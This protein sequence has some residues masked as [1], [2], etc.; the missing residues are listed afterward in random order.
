M[1]YFLSAI[2]LITLS[3]C[4]THYIYMENSIYHDPTPLKGNFGGQYSIGYGEQAEIPIASPSALASLKINTCPN[5]GNNSQNGC[6][7]GAITPLRVD[8]RLKIYEGLQ[9]YR[10]PDTFGI[11]YQI[12]GSDDFNHLLSV[13][14]GWGGLSQKSQSQNLFSTSTTENA[15][16]KVS[17]RELSL[18]YGYRIS[19]NHTVIAQ[20]NYV[21]INTSYTI[22]T[23]VNGVVTSNAHYNDK[24]SHSR[25]GPAYKFTSNWFY[26]WAELNF[27]KTKMSYLKTYDDPSGSFAIGIIW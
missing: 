10:H 26:I 9:L 5:T 24:G 21:E 3:A 6:N 22:E 18:S 12:V 20:A 19:P 25:F 16:S 23:V 8:A 27:G 14:A 1:K 4:S 11:Q 15:E 17:L 7:V 13:R 2:V